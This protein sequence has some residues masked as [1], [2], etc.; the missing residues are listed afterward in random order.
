[1][2]IEGKNFGSLG[3]FGAAI[4]DNT[5][6]ELRNATSTTDLNFIYSTETE[7][8]FY[9]DALTYECQEGYVDLTPSSI[10]GD[11]SLTETTYGITLV[12]LGDPTYFRECSWTVAYSPVTEGWVSYYSFK[13][14][15]YIGYHNYFQTGIN[16]SSDSTELGLWSHL[17]FVS[18]YQVFYGKLYPW[19]ID[20]SLQ[21]KYTGSVL[22]GISYYLDARK[23]YS[24]WDYTDGFGIGFNK[25]IV[26]NNTQN[27]GQLNLVFQQNNNLRQQIDY[28]QYNP[29]SVSILQSEIDGKFSFNYLYN[30]IKNEKSGLP[31]FINNCSQTDKTIDNRLLDYRNMHRDRLRGDYLNVRLSNDIE[32]KYKMIFRFGM[33]DRTFYE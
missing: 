23:Y 13:P 21:T 31:I 25:A 17:P 32:S 22:N 28:P 2:K 20:Y 3:M 29:T 9:E 16:Y 15:Y 33:D 30:L 24:E 4:L 1:V 7:R 26:Y 19:T 11:C 6:V 18:S 8:Y 27:S 5:D 10:C 14:N 12:E